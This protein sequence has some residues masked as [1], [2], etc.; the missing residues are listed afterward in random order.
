MNEIT[1][2]F[3]D[4]IAGYIT[5]ADLGNKKFSLKTTDDREFD[6]YLTPATYAEVTRNLGEPFQDPGAPLDTLLTPG[7]YLHAYGVFYPESE[8]LVFE[9]KRVI[10]AGRGPTEFRGEAPLWW[11]DQIRQLAEFYFR[12]Q[13]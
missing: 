5:S 2:T 8:G 1:W 11:V 13:F 7:R 6:V 12:A 4:T 3:S 10:L 9:A